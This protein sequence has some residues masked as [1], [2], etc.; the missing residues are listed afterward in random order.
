MRRRGSSEEISPEGVSEA[1]FAYFEERFGLDRSLFG[2]YRLY[3][4][5]KGRVYLGPKRVPDMPKIATI[6]LMVA[7]VSG[8]VKPS[9]N[10]L[11]AMGMHVGKS[12]VELERGQAIRYARGE[13]IVFAPDAAKAAGASDGYLLLRYLGKQLGCGFLKDGV[14]RNML[15][16]AKRLEIRLI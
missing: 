12:A 7:R 15:P 4:A 11:Q 9:T 6:G 1:V 10:L 13:D 14:I 8:Q 16:K 5:S 3:L 2:G